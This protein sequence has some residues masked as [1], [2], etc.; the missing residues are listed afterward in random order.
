MEAT[1]LCH[2]LGSAVWKCIVVIISDLI[3][4]SNTGQWLT[5][6]NLA[7][8]ASYMCDLAIMYHAVP[9]IRQDNQHT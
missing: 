9:S 1:P 8:P 4:R 6:C 3:G 5:L 2:G 7:T